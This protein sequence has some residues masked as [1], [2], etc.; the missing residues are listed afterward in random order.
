[1]KAKLFLMAAAAMTLATSCSND[2]VVLQNNAG[3][4]IAFTAVSE[5]ASRAATAYCNNNLPGDFD[6]WSSVG[7][8]TYFGGVNYS[9]ANPNTAGS[10]WTVTN[11]ENQRYWPNQEKINF[12]AAKNYGTCKAWDPATGTLSFDFS[13]KGTVG[14]QEDFIYAV[15]TDVQRDPKDNVSTQ[16]LNFRHALSQ[17]V[18]QAK[19][20]NSKLYVEVSGVEVHNV[21]NAGTYTLPTASTTDNIESHDQSAEDTANR[22]TWG[23]TV[24]GNATYSVDFT[25]VPLSATLASLTTADDTEKAGEWNGNTMLLMPQTTAAKDVATRSEF[26]KNDGAYFVLDVCIWNVAGDNVDKEKDV[27]LVGTKTIAEGQETTYKTAK[28]Y[29]PVS[30]AWEQGK[31]YTYTFIFG[32]GNGGYNQDGN[33]V[34]V[35][36]TFNVTVDDFVANSDTQVGMDE[37]YEKQGN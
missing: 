8:A 31:K 3:N 22:G 13:V 5:N 32:K 27:M 23:N 29:I 11:V 34:L 14:E 21:K 28:V 16:A 18:F 15:Q 35:P 37:I 12:Y 7:G 6:V 26:G 9:N 2:E 4:Q 25:A 1:M 20:T 10:T 17:V 30:I 36:I 24:T 19:N 33:D